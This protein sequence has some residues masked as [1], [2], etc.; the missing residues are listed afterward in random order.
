MK[1]NPRSQQPVRSGVLPPRRKLVSA[2]FSL[3]TLF[4][5]TGTAH[6]QTQHYRG[7]TTADDPI[8]QTNIGRSKLDYRPQYDTRPWEAAEPPPPES[9]PPHKPLTNKQACG[10]YVGGEFDNKTEFKKCVA[11]LARGDE[12]Y[13]DW[14]ACA[15]E[16]GHKGLEQG[17]CGPI[18]SRAEKRTMVPAICFIEMT[19]QNAER[20]FKICGD[21]S[22]CI[23]KPGECESYERDRRAHVKAG[24][25][26]CVKEKCK[27]APNPYAQKGYIWDCASYRWKWEDRSFGRPKGYKT[28]ADAC[29][30]RPCRM[31][32]N[33]YMCAGGNLGY[34]PRKL[35]SQQL[36]DLGRVP[37]ERYVKIK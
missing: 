11:R 1:L 22:D 17:E 16:A 35:R 25:L 32:D 36:R 3:A 21:L 23:D 28:L 24:R 29:V 7:P 5:A 37:S 6:A 14:L 26:V 9:P 19:D 13:R 15:G 34:V 12:A 27:L 31:L 30:K 2:V 18:P 4:L 33:Q 10:L 8:Y 20:L